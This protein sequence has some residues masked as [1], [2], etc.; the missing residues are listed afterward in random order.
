M[1]F[2]YRGDKLDRRHFYSI[3]NNDFNSHNFY[4]NRKIMRM[5]WLF[6]NNIQKDKFVNSVQDDK[7]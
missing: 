3:D 4:A 1:T 6:D 5:S 7:F 2:Y